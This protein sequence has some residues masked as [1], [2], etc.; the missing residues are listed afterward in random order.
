M[1]IKSKEDWLKLL[2]DAESGDASAMNEVAMY[3]RDGLIIDNIEIVSIDHKASFEW[4]KQSFEKGDVNGMVEYAHHLSYPE[5]EVC[6]KNVKKAIQ[7]YE[8]ALKKGSPEA[9]HS[10]GIEYRNKQN[11][12]K[13]FEY[14]SIAK[15]SSEFY[16]DLSL[17]LCYYYGVGVKK[18]KQK[19][20]ELFKQNNPG[21]S[22]AYE[23]NEINYLLGKIYLEGEIVNQ[24]INKARKYLELANE[25]GDHR[26][27]FELL[28]I[29]GRT[30]LLN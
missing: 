19:A 22:S 10:L 16:E 28:L 6:I 11:F 2:A 1:V 27:A 5:N 14:Y 3:F 12:E 4:T 20:F 26:S 29:I 30:E 8:Q 9:A 18:D 23:T 21:T 13:A 17:G 25:D 24:D 7:I 15:T